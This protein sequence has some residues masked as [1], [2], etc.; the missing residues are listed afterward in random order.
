MNGEMCRTEGHHEHPFTYFTR[1]KN[2]N[3]STGLSLPSVDKRKRASKKERGGDGHVHDV[4]L[5]HRTSK[6]SK[7]VIKYEWERL[8]T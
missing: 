2:I 8:T 7:K 3:N 1:L 4:H 6:H 5:R